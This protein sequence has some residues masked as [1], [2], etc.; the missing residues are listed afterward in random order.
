ML[1]LR[2][3][4]GRGLFSIYHF[5][6][7]FFY[8]ATSVAEA[9]PSSFDQSPSPKRT[10]FV[11]FLINT[12]GFSKESAVSSS[13]KV[14]RLTT[15]RNCD[16]VVRI[17][18]NCG[19]NDDQIKDL[20]LWI[21]KVLLYR[22]NETLEPKIRVFLE[23]GLSV[24]DLISLL[25]R[26]PNLFELGLHSRIIPTIDYLKTLLGSNERVVE[27]IN[28]SRWLFSTSI[29]LKM[30][31]AN[32]M[33]LQSYGFSNE[34]IGKFVHKNARHFTQAPEWL[35][36]KLNWVEGKQGISRDSTEFF[37]CFHAIASS[38]ISA[39]DKKMEIYK[40]FGFSEDELSLL[41]KNQPYCF[42]LSED[43]IRDKLSFFM[44]ELGYTPSYL[45]TCPSLFSLS[46]EKR[47][48]PRNEVLKI[49]K[50]RML[51]KSKSLITLV[52]YPELRFLG[53]LRG[54]E[55]E[56]PSLYETYINSIRD[57]GMVSV[58]SLNPRILNMPNL[59]PARLSLTMFFM[60]RTEE[61]NLLVEG[62]RTLSFAKR[63]GTQIRTKIKCLDAEKVKV[64][65][66]QLLHITYKLML[67]ICKMATSDPLR[68]F[69]MGSGIGTMGGIKL[70][71]NLA[72]EKQKRLQ[73][74]ET[75]WHDKIRH[76]P[77]SSY[78]AIVF[79]MF[80]ILQTIP[81]S[82]L[83]SPFQS[84]TTSFSSSPKITTQSTP[85]IVDYLINS[86]G[87]HEHEAIAVS[88]KVPHVS[89]TNSN[90]VIN[91]FKN[92]G[93]NNIQIRNI[94]SASPGI[95]T[96][97][98]TKT[99]EPKLRIFREL[100]LP[101]PDLVK[102]I[103]RDTFIFRKGLH[104]QI[105]PTVDYLRK[106]L[107]CDEKVVEM[108]NRSKWVL[109]PSKTLTRISE[110]ISLLQKYGLCDQKILKFLVTNPQYMKQAPDLVETKLQYLEGKLGISRCSS[111]FIHGLGAALYRSE[112]DIEKN[113]QIFHDFGWSD[114]EIGTLFRAQPYCLN[115]SEA[116][117]SDKLNFFMK[118]L[119]YTPC[120]LMGRTSFWTLS[121]E[122][123]IKPRNEVLKIL[124]EKEVV[125]DTPSLAT[126]LNY[127]E[128]KF[129]GF[130]QS[131]ESQIPGLCETYKNS[132]RGF[133]AK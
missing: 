80:K 61:L 46:L 102:L 39:M 92:Y 44:M 51:A 17:L 87:F 108:I 94:I 53:F 48:K 42:A 11:D 36:S 3:H 84:S 69:K 28:R 90:S 29:A 5:K 97:K 115:K 119:E 101:V 78:L 19:F 49:L 68:C 59:F 106:L 131:F 111:N 117:I 72:L 77:K 93:L 30:F 33:L 81:F 62:S 10:E 52:N 54:F 22:A 104:T 91:L 118:E 105:I 86:L 20:V 7:H 132:L 113:I 47:V 6:S 103:K 120:Y 38:S 66:F 110:N 57:S 9:K 76:F 35:T 24:P 50:E 127:S 1:Y 37:R 100:G 89:T 71:L 25:K 34:K 88:S 15:T 133:K 85:F 56:I 14:R 8:S 26:N 109:L 95:L 55:D 63:E 40:S 67:V 31:S 122:K 12:L 65:D 125:K 32:V 18:K 116:Y 58:N 107:G 126:I 114:L 129:L 70:V 112:S 64:P 13:S 130:L 74:R 45:V 73:A 96:L 98:P 41:F 16:S 60:T 23:L 121:L 2:S 82:Y 27:T 123:R 124:K 79:M 75:N 128:L 43:T 99:L 21:P 4:V 83:R